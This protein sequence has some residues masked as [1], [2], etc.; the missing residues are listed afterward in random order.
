LN[1]RGARSKFRLPKIEITDDIEDIIRNDEFLENE[2]TNTNTTQQDDNSNNNDSKSDNVKNSNVDVSNNNINNNV[3]TD[4]TESKKDQL[5]KNNDD[6]QKDKKENENDIVVE[7][8]ALNAEQ[9]SLLEE[10]EDAFLVVDND[11]FGFIPFETFMKILNDADIE[12]SSKDRVYFTK[13]LMLIDDGVDYYGFLRHVRE[14]GANTNKT[15][16]EVIETIATN[17]EEL[18]KQAQ[19]SDSYEEDD[20][21]QHIPRKKPNFSRAST[22]NQS[23]NF[24]SSKNLDPT[25]PLKQLI[26]DLALDDASV[27]FPLLKTALNIIDCFPSDDDLQYLIQ[28]LATD[29]SGFIDFIAFLQFLEENAKIPASPLNLAKVIA[30][31]CAQ[32][33]IV[34]RAQQQLEEQKLKTQERLAKR[35]ASLLAANSKDHITELA[36]AEKKKKALRLRDKAMQ[37]R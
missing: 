22:G 12:L 31:S 26:D 6:E 9:E 20:N 2:N 37:Y 25:N 17:Q 5:N 19:E 35:K 1:Y 33:R 16:Q 32:L 23:L 4:T 15:I 7:P 28:H 24:E 34:Q 11:C 14:L 30:D 13:T 27:D 29:D 21:D 3:N 18:E 10:L 8:L 36:M